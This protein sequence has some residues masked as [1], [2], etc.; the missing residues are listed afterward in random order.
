MRRL[1]RPVARDGAV[2]GVAG[3]LLAGLGYGV[4][5]PLGVSL[6]LAGRRRPAR[7]GPGARAAR[8][9]HGDRAGAVRAGRGRRRSSGPHLAFLLVPALL[10]GG[11]RSRV[12]P[13]GATGRTVAAAVPEP[14]RAGQAAEASSRRPLRR[15]RQADV[16]A[17]GGLGARGRG[18]P[19]LEVRPRAQVVADLEVPGALGPHRRA[20]RRR[21]AR[22]RR[23]SR[24]T[25]AAPNVSATQPT[26]GEP[27]GVAP[28]KTIMYSAITRPRIAGGVDIWIAEFAAVIIVSEARPT[29]TQ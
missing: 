27:I 2:G 29:G 21:A 10:V 13:C 22:D 6:L 5:Y 14:G 24:S 19:D 7:P 25:S 17:R 23:R 18:V 16:L 11:R 1:A 8:R 4:H 28:T 20:A 3:L 9:G 26:I 12:A 15:E